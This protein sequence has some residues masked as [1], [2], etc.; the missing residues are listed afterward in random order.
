MAE[1]NQIP[2]SDT[3]PSVVD[4]PSNWKAIKQTR[5]LEIQTDPIP[6]GRAEVQTK[7]RIHKEVVN[8]AILH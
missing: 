1:D 2:F 4:F 6:T 3:G 8:L 5:E 7:E